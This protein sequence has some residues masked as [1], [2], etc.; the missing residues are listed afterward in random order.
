[1]FLPNV[2]DARAIQ[3]GVAWSIRKLPEEPMMPRIADDRVGYFTT[4][5]KDFTK[6]KDETFFTHYANKW[7]LEKKDPTAAVSEPKQPIVYYI[8]NTVPTEYVPYMIDGCR[9]VAEGL[10]G[11]GLQERHHRQAG[12]DQ[13]RGPQLRSGRRALQHHSLEHERPGVVRRH[14]TLA[15]RPAHG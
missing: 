9:A 4:S 2:P 5:Y 6:E 8:D 15:R 13:G 12:A 3:V 1:M 7:R 10:R 11:R 14:R